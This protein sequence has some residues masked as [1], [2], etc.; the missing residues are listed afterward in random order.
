[1]AVPQMSDGSK[2]DNGVCVGG[3]LSKYSLSESS[4]FG[5]N[6]VNRVSDWER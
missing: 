2:V 6:K 3:I 5:K 4:A 1:V